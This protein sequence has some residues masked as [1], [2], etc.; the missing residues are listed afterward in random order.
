MGTIG[1]SFEIVKHVKWFF[2][3]SD[4]DLAYIKLQLFLAKQTRNTK[5]DTFQCIKRLS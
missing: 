5:I 1:L 3:F 2:S 4:N